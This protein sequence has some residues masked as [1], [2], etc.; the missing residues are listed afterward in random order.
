MIAL[1]TVLSV[2]KLFEMPYGGSITL[3]SMLP[4]VIIAHRYGAGYGF[5]SALVT[6][7]IQALLG[8]KN[9]SYFTTPLSLIAL[10][11]FD[12]VLAFGVFG[13][14]GIFKK[15]IGSQATAATVGALVA[16]VLRYL[17]HVIS[18]AT[19]WA[20]ISIPTAAALAYSFIYNATYM[21]PETIVLTIATLYIGSVIDFRFTE[22]KRIAAKS[23]AGG[24]SWAKPA[25]GL[26]VCGAIIVDI[27][28]IFENLQDAET[29]EFTL[30][31]IAEVNWVAVITVTAVALISAAVLLIV[32]N[33][34]KELT[35]D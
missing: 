11:V 9:F 23:K 19:V 33:S 28:E 27:A 24:I 22:P 1:S 7:V 29:G 2:I 18:G 10:G 4:I 5:S 20:G 26:L 17:C 16:S 8:M 30:A 12:Y 6:S 13:I 32:A 31:N 34:R 25:A 14:V 21:L 15:K 3:A 35:K